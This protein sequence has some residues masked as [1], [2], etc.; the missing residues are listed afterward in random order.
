MT[1]QLECKDCGF[2]AKNKAGHLSHIR[3]HGGK[4]AP[5]ATKPL[6]VMDMHN[7]KKPQ[8]CT[9]CNALPV[10]ATEL[11][12]LLL[13]TVFALTAVLLTSVYALEAQS[14]RIAVLESQLQ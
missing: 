4:P 12:T 11:V 2:Q 14:D 7:H 6:E 10:G 8:L 13:V 9:A 5:K 3:S 1:H